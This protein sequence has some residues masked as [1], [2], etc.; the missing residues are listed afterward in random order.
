M[1]DIVNDIAYVPESIPDHSFLYSDIKIE[2]NYKTNSEEPQVIR[3]PKY[4]VSTVPN[5][6]LLNVQIHSKVMET[7][8]KIEN[9]INV[10]SDIQN[11]YDQFQ[12]LIK[13]EMNNKLQIKTSCFGL[14]KNK[15][16]RYKPYWNDDLS[17][18]W[19]KVCACEKKWLRCNGPSGTKQRLKTDYSAERKIFD[20]L[21]RK[22]KRQYQIL[23]RKKIEEKLC[24][25]IQREF[26]KSVGKIGIA[27]ERKP[28]IPMAVLGPNGNVN[29]NKNDV[30]NKWKSDFQKFFQRNGG[31][32]S[33]L[34]ASTFNTEIDITPLNQ[35]ISRDEVVDAV[36]SAKLRI[37]TG[38]DEILTEVLKNDTAIDLL[39][40]II[41]GCFNLGK[42][43]YQWNSGI[44]NPILKPGSDDDRNPMNY[45]GITLVSVPCKI[46]CNILNTRLSSWLENN[47][48]L[49][50]EQN[51][52]RRNRSCKEHIQPLH[53]ILNDQ[54]YLENQHMC[55]L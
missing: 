36:I 27:S 6:F 29:T 45:R 33:Q 37:A 26:W 53:S 25:S 46:Y 11:T 8:Q 18:Q 2:L 13:C 21:N 23:E 54:K 31:D 32:N 1:S 40:Q 38:I 44:I 5:D 12:G 14:N 20:H 15:K 34:D 41:S 24:V 4:K 28:C 52:F 49:C 9:Y 48:I 3:K 17:S 10:S 51:G 55:A 22:Y 35:Q 19:I 16:S 43:P 50:D 7:I 47:E 42:V 30:L 39:F